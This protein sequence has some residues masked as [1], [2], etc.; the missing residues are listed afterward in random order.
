MPE[1]RQRLITEQ[2]DYICDKCGKGRMKWG[3]VT[4]TS[5][6]PWFPSTCDNCGHQENMREH[7]PHIIH[8]TVKRRTTRPQG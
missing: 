4:L 1:T 3:G 8:R 7:Y 2:V 6:P 5:N